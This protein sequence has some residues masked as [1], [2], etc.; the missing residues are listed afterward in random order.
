[1]VDDKEP[2]KVTPRLQVVKEFLQT[3]K[4][5]VGILHTLLN[6]SIGKC[7]CQLC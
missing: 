6:V 4:N 7:F 1:L 5:Y 2:V 3:E